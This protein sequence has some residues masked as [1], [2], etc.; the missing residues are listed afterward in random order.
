MEKFI[1]STKHSIKRANTG[2]KV[3]VDEFIDEY[4]RVAQ[5]FVD[6]LWIEV[7]QGNLEVPSM[8]ST[9]DIPTDTWL[10]ARALK[11]AAT[12][13]CGIVKGTI[14]KTKK[15]QYIIDK[16]RKY[17]QRVPKKLRKNVKKLFPSKPTTENINAELNSIC[18][19][20]NEGSKEFDGFINMHC[21]VNNQRNFQVNLPVNYT[22]NSNKWMKKGERLNSFLLS[23]NEV[24]FRWEIETELKDEGKTV[25]SDQGKK[26]V[27]TLSDGQTPP[28]E[29]PHGHTCD[30][31]LDKLSRKKKGSKAFKKA[32]DHREN[33]F[34]WSMNQL[35]FTNIK[36]V[37]FEG[38]INVNFG[39][40]V[41]RGLKH[42]TFT[43]IRDKFYRL[44]EECGVRIQTDSST[45][46]SQRC[47][48]C[49]L[50][51]KSN[52]KGKTYTCKN[53]GYVED[54]DLNAALNHQQCLPD[55][56]GLRSL[57]LNRKGFFWNPCGCTTLE[58]VEIAVPLS[59]KSIIFY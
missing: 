29:C 39:K 19:E 8:I 31:I 5:L 18:I 54:A 58:G 50:V 23:K 32:Q 22:R 53:C 28:Q 3:F 10:S 11:C 57:K 47:S 33:F 43:L 41:S 40:N 6:H 7:E 35:N 2:K 51:L 17:R 20:F 14:E 49:G 15:R 21:L 24:Q 36:Q 4:R 46:Y 44:S 56:S 42:W 13:A 25:G 34:N 52:R 1:R 9:T 27:I 26:T 30:S 48:K 16:C 38:L 37:N 55:V 59:K 12:Q 45:Y